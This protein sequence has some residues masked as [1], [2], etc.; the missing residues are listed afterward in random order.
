ML[1]LLF[2]ASER[3]SSVMGVH[4]VSP[5][6]MIT[7]SGLDM[8]LD[9]KPQIMPTQAWDHTRS[10]TNLLSRDVIITQFVESRAKGQGKPLGCK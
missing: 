8:E 2:M 4:D 10:L 5:L 1:L 6:G 9:H 7:K 3:I